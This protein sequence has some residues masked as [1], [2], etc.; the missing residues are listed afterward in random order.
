MDNRVLFQ[1]YRFNLLS[2]NGLSQN[3]VDSYINDLNLFFST[4]P[5][6]AEKITNKEIINYLS[7]LYELGLAPSSISRKRSALQSFFSYLDQNIFN[8]NLSIDFDKIPS[9]RYEYHIPEVLSKEEI[10]DFLDKLPTETIFEIRNKIILELLY[11]TG[12]RI[13]ELIDLSIHSIHKQDKLLLVCGKGNKQRYVPLSDYILDLL[14]MYLNTV[15]LELKVANKT[16][17]DALF[18]NKFGKKFSRMGLW[19]M[20]HKALL[21]YGISKMITPHTFRHCFATH[22]VEAGVNLRIIQ[23]LLGHT[24]I[25]TTQIYTNIDIRYLIENHRINHPK[26]RI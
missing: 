26:N 21:E 3:T 2:E 14:Q 12:L 13:S 8:E 18:L 4:Y 16:N 5:M 6:D 10:I 15:R 23:E 19:K 7:S 1:K 24:S 17:Q 9:V 25:S 20:I 22:L 11:S